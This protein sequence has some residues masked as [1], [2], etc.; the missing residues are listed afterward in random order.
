ML[1]RAI[2]VRAIVPTATLRQANQWCEWFSEQAWSSKKFR[3]YDPHHAVYRTARQNFDIGAQMVVRCIAKVAAAYKL[4]QHAKRRF[5]PFGSVA[6]DARM[7]KW[8]VEN[9]TVSI[10]SVSGRLNIPFLCGAPQM[11]STWL[12][13]ARRANRLR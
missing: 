8:R 11:L 7:L 12:P 6:Y 13:P 1:I 9:Q 2:G 10:W 5:R 4:D 3:A